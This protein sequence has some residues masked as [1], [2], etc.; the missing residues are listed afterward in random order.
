MSFDCEGNFTMM[1]IIDLRKYE[2]PYLIFGINY[3]V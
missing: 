3:N 1:K 2:K